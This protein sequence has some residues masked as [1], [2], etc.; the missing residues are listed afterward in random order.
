MMPGYLSVLES[1]LTARV[2]KKASLSEGHMIKGA[3][4]SVGLRHLQ[5]ASNQVAGSFPARNM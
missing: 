4:G 3:A 1:N 5:I 2:T